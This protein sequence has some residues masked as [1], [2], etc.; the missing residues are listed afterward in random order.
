MLS[1]PRDR[2]RVSVGLPLKNGGGQ[3]M[4]GGAVGCLPATTVRAATAAEFSPRLTAGGSS[5]FPHVTGTGV[6]EHNVPPP[7][8][9]DPLV[10]L[11]AGDERA[12]ETLVER[13]YAVI[14]AVARGYVKTHA[15]AG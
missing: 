8:E 1:P 4:I 13:H 10:R 6:E 15:A 2:R 3:P 12:F 14:L 9:A 7:Q 5:R 11:R